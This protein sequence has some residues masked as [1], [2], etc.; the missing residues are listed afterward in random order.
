VRDFIRTDSLDR[1]FNHYIPVIHATFSALGFIDIRSITDVLGFIGSLPGFVTLLTTIITGAATIFFRRASRLVTKAQVDETLEASQHKKNIE[2][3]EETEKTQ[4][5][6]IFA[7]NQENTLLRHKLEDRVKQ[8]KAL[9][10]RVAQLE[11]SLIKN[12]IEL[13]ES[14]F[15]EEEI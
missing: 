5:N 12:K 10:G 15:L 2:L 3:H 7:L 14:T 9:H 13:P 11:Q 6:N 8:V 1:T 4:Q